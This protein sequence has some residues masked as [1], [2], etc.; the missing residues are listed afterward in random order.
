MFMFQQRNHTR[1]ENDALVSLVANR[2]ANQGVFD[3][4]LRNVSDNFTHQA[5]SQADEHRQRQN[6]LQ[7]RLDQIVAE[8]TKA[9][10]KVHQEMDQLREGLELATNQLVLANQ[11]LEKERFAGRAS[12]STCRS[13]R[14]ELTAAN[15]QLS[16][17][18]EEHRNT[19]QVNREVV[20]D[21]ETELAE[22]RAMEKHSRH[23]VLE[24]QQSRDAQDVLISQLRAQLVKAKTYR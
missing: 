16:R 18:S 5:A 17:L 15:E 21:L 19:R 14:A 24:L 13:L 11:D 7:D 10:R 9:D 22:T 12:E 6:E 8:T 4:A 20:V 2:F 1:V 23:I 3:A